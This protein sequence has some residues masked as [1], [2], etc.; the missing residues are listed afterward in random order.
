MRLRRTLH[1]AI[2]LTVLAAPAAMAGSAYADEPIRAIGDIVLPDTRCEMALSQ[3]QGVDV[4]VGTTRDDVTTALDEHGTGGAIAPTLR[5]DEWTV[6]STG[7]KAFSIA[8]HSAWI[9]P[10]TGNWINSR[11]DYQSAGGGISVG[12]PLDVAVTDLRDVGT[13]S[14]EAVDPGKVGPVPAVL[15]TT[16]RFRTT[17]EVPENSYLNRLDLRYAADNGVTFFLNGV[18]IGGFDPS[19]ADVSAFQVEHPLA[20]AGPLLQEGTNVLDAVVTDYGVATGLLV[21]GGYHGC[22]VWTRGPGVCLDVREN[23]AYAWPAEHIDLST[24]STGGVRHA[25][26]AVDDDWHSRRFTFP[27]AY[28]VAPYSGWFNQLT[29]ANWIHETPNA[30]TGAIGRTYVYDIAFTVGPN[31]TYQDLDFR[32]AA[33]DNA[34]FFLNGTLIGTGGNWWS[35]TPFH[36]NGLFTTGTNVLRVEV[37]DSGL[38]ASGLLVQGGANVCYSHMA[39]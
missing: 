10:A 1:S 7:Q 5:D 33:D 31:A 15:P 18:P 2:A 27:D 8:K 28:S 22:R 11:A 4:A 24:G 23:Q 38:V 19:P 30:T 9:A 20:Y 6:V 26:G 37:I 29:T 36:W 12:G 13:V 25:Y 16:T 34:R 3:S 35:L 32:Y 39:S 21:R 14:I 17:F